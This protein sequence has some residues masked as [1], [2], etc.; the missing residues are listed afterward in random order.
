MIKVYYSFLTES[1]Q[2]ALNELL[3]RLPMELQSRFHSF[4][5]R[6]DGFLTVLGRLLL[7]KSLRYFST[8][9]LSLAHIKLTKY[10][11]PY[12][13]DVLDFNIT[14]SSNLAACIVSDQGKVGID[15]EEV[16]PVPIEDFK[17]I[18]S[19]EELVTVHAAGSTS[20]YSFF[21][22]WTEK[23]AVL[24]A[25]GQGFL[26]DNSKIE[27]INSRE[28]LDELGF[29]LTTL[30]LSDSYMVNAAIP[31]STGAIAIEEVKVLTDLSLD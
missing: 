20:Y 24:K 7:L 2:A 19:T 5:N 6:Q 9:D 25:I 17:S 13:N 4:A 10:K 29:Q 23:E 8:N 3:P 15:A 1:L 16:R 27:R 28:S 14:H 31:N 26:Y 12:F 22:Y 30:V 11:R 21:R 18:L